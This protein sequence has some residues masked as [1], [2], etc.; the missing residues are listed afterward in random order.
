MLA[1]TEVPSGALDSGAIIRKAKAR[2]LPAQIASGGVLTLAIVGLGIAGY[3][4]FLPTQSADQSTMLE[5]APQSE[6][7]GSTDT[8]TYTAEGLK[9]APAEKLNL[10][11]AP[12]AEVAPNESGLELIP[13]FPDE[14]PAG[15]ETVT[16]TVTL[17]NNGPEHVVGTTAA[18]PAIT[19]SQDGIVVWHSNGPMIMMVMMVDLDSGESMDYQATFTPVRCDVEDDLGE[20]FRE[21]LPALPPGEYQISAAIDFVPVSGTA[22]DNPAIL[23]LIVGPPTAVTLR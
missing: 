5:S 23:P 14:A 22:S 16:G 13:H 6:S 20:S 15:A 1:L 19:V 12:L 21:D 4:S 10:C 2:R 8:D 18:A 9:R 11:G 17:V 3:Q 7:G